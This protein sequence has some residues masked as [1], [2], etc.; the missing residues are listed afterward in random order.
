MGQNI[1]EISA[2]PKLE[3]YIASNPAEHGAEVLL[4]AE[5][6]A[7]WG[8]M[9]YLAD[10][11]VVP[12]VARGVGDVSIVGFFSDSEV[13]STNP[14]NDAAL[15]LVPEVKWERRGMHFDDVKWY[16]ASSLSHALRVAEMN[17]SATEAARYG[18]VEDYLVG[19][20]LELPRYAGTNALKH[21]LR[22]EL[23]E[24]FS[25]KPHLYIHKVGSQFRDV[26]ADINTESILPVHEMRERIEDEDYA[27]F[28][29]YLVKNFAVI[30]ERVDER[31]EELYGEAVKA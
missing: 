18:L 25:S 8:H 3:G 2:D 20:E 16:D 5:L 28:L 6:M 19:H 17:Q 11:V 13:R 9:E 23:S 31:F 22:Y 29:D 27:D 10:H 4:D 30:R 12:S 21:I 1:Q 24:R 7:M 15:K 26:V 14:L